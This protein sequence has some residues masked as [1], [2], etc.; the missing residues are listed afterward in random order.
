MTNYARD[1]WRCRYFWLSLVQLDLR[2][3]YRGS[4]M[5]LGWSL[6]RPLLMTTI[7]CVVFHGLF[8]LPPLEYA[9]YALTGLACWSFLTGVAVEGCHC[10]NRAELHIRQHRAPLAIYPLRTAL[11]A[12]AH[13]L[14]A[15]ALVVVLA[16]WATG[17]GHP[18]S[19]LYL[20]PAVVLLFFLGWS[21]AIILGLANVH[22]R[23]TQHLCDVVFQFL[24]YATPV[25]YPASLLQDRGLGWLVMCNPLA[26]FLELIRRPILNGQAP[27]VSAFAAAL[28]TVLVMALVAGLLLNRLQRTIVFRF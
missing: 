1:I 3:R 7:V 6:L 4:V 14:A 12:T 10:L 16:G 9:A 27:S 25:L 11:G 8:E 26:C 24:F 28:L 19:L 15:L 18:V 21:A 22:F 2:A 5:G 20:V 17:F 23:D 13:L